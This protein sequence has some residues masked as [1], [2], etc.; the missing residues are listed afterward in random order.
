MTMKTVVNVSCDGVDCKHVRAN[1]T[2]HWL[3]GYNDTKAIIVTT[4][5]PT[6]VALLNMSHIPEGVKDF[7]GQECAGKWVSKMF[8]EIN[9]DK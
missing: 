1:D 3:I 7:C 2:N 5:R 8:S 4:N 9:Y 6:L